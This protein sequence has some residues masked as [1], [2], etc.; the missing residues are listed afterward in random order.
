MLVVERWILARLRNR[1]SF[2]LSELNQAIAE[3]V[4][5]LNARPM[6]RLGVSRRNL[7]FELD[8]PALKSLPA[9]PHVYAEWCPAGLGSTTMSTLPAIITR[10]RTG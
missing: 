3:L 6:R 1:R 8:R 10:C 9:E 4:G 7:F 5:D 2:S